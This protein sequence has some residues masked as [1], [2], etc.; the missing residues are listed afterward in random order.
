MIAV[1]VFIGAAIYLGGVGGIILFFWTTLVWCGR[2]GPTGGGQ[3]DGWAAP[4]FSPVCCCCCGWY[5]VGGGPLRDAGRC[6]GTG[7]AEEEFN[8]FS[9]LCIG[10]SL[11][12]H[13]SF[14]HAC[15]HA[16][17]SLCPF[18]TLPPYHP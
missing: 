17:M 12:S 1:L 5:K 15:M 8:A 6:P 4:P 18:T 9:C 7:E 10:H 13:C 3:L 16:C 2:G 14:R 11:A